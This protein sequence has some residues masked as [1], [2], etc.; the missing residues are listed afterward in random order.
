MYIVYAHFGSQIPKY[1]LNNISNVAKTIQKYNVVLLSDQSRPRKLYPSVQQEMIEHDL[2]WGQIQ[3]ELEHPKDFRKNFWFTSLIRLY[4]LGRFATL[5]NMKLIHIESDVILSEDFPF[6]KFLNMNE[7]LAFPIFNQTMG[8]ASILFINGSEGGKL[9]MEK[10][11]SAARANSKTT[12]ML[13]LGDLLRDHES[14]VKVLPSF[15]DLK[16]DSTY[17][18]ELNSQASKN[19]AQFGGIFDGLEIGQY[20]FGDDPRN[21]RG[22]SVIRRKN[23]YGF[24]DL[25][26]TNFEFFNGR[27]FPYLANVEGNFYPIFSMH[28][29]SK[30]LSLFKSTNSRI[31][32]E[33]FN[34]SYLPQK[35]ILYFN[36][37]V[38]SVFASIGRRVK[39]FWNHD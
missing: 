24:L 34:D 12:D 31:I 6:D 35:K 26:N 33:F 7:L 38:N 17:D 9:L 32:S 10:C 3:D 23:P 25:K 22:F 18:T 20:I 27:S 5:N 13:V 4:E 14:K 1:L 8:I 19:L 2:V 21:N 28:I 36:T 30:N 15:A 37:L 29:H 16:T 11:L 39:L